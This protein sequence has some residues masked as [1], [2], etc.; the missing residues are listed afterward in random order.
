[1]QEQLR[2]RDNDL[3]T[4]AENYDVQVNDSRLK[5]E[6]LEDK[7]SQISPHLMLKSDPKAHRRMLYSLNAKRKMR[8]FWKPKS[9]EPGSCPPWVWE[10]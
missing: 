5:I 6:A 10:I 7:V 4:A 9:S 8:S 3:R 2:L 1:M